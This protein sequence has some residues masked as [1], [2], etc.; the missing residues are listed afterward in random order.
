MAPPPP[1]HKLIPGCGFLVD[2]FRY[3]GHPSA[4]AYLLSHAH[5]GELPGCAGCSVMMLWRKAA[6][7]LLRSGLPGLPRANL[8][9][10]AF[11]TPCNSSTTSPD[12]RPL[13]GAERQL[14]GGPHL[15]QPHHRP[16][17]GTHAGSG[18]PLAGAAPPGHAYHDPRWAAM[19]GWRMAL[20]CI[21]AFGS[22]HWSSWWCSRKR[23]AGML[24]AGLG[25]TRAFPITRCLHLR[26]LPCRAGVEVTLVDANHCP[27]AVQFLFR[28]PDGRRFIHTGGWNACCE[29]GRQWLGSLS[30]EPAA[31]PAANPANCTLA[32]VPLRS[33]CLGSCYAGDMRF[34]PALLDNPHVQ[35]FRQVGCGW[36]VGCT[37]HMLACMFPDCRL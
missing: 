31:A 19:V 37:W 23:Q 11:A 35:A 8:L 26:S 16:A 14:V 34:S 33:F 1:A 2:G 6:A 17:H 21:D 22:S 13:H 10:S 29:R 4:K 9:P 12:R 5:S 32:S 7:A 25:C 36:P 18:A 28:L 15:L 24:C 30:F 3:A 20:P 27:G